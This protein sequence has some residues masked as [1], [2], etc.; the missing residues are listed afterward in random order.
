MSQA[1]RRPAAGY[2]RL[3]GVLGLILAIL[4]FVIPAY[5]VLLGSTAAAVLG[6]GA[7]WGGSSGLGI[8]TLILV[9]LNCV[10]SPTFWLAMSLGGETGLDVLAWV[11]VAGVVAM[12][13]LIARPVRS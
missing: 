4:G 7:L 2:S 13:I 6:V 9:V 8:A 10:I 11:C 12:L 1:Q 5:G 3:C